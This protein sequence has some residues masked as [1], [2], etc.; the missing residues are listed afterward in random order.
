MTAPK[1]TV[2]ANACVF[3]LEAP[4]HLTLTPAA[5]KA[6]ARFD[7]VA[8]SGKP[9]QGHWFWGNLG[10]ELAGI[11]AKSRV[12]ILM[13]HDPT[14]RIGYSDARE[15]TKRGLQMQGEFLRSSAL[16]AQ[17]RSESLDG[18]PFEASV[19][20]RPVKVERVAE[21]ETVEVNGY[22]MTGPGH[23]FRR[24]ELR[25]VSF[26]A[27]GADSNTSAAALA[28]E[29]ELAVELSQ[30]D[31]MT[32][33]DTK[34][35]TAA[36]SPAPAA[37]AALNADAIRLEAAA[38]ER[39]RIRG[40]RELSTSDQAQLCEELVEAGATIE[41]AAVRLAA[42]LKGRHEAMKAQLAASSDKSL[43]AGNRGTEKPAATPLDAVKALPDGPEKWTKLYETDPQVRA[44]WHS[45]AAFSAYQ[46]SLVLGTRSFGAPKTEA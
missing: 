26:C 43:S 9:I 18:F 5:D 45:A 14:Q 15:I 44:E 17:V 11:K 37:P 41:A 29:G 28:Q 42:D 3:A 38:A 32:P 10:I 1:L 13:D 35:A 39:A 40:I 16:A 46:E 25:E 2:P 24:S 7:V 30:H 33:T 8:N 36:P 19:N 31:T 6:P 20:L 21:G 12:P 34:G 27:L 22:E 23:V 4:D